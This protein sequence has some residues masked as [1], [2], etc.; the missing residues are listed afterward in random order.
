MSR[1][2]LRPALFGPSAEPFSNQEQTRGITGELGRILEE[3]VM[4]EWR[5]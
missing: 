4:G 1:N 2:V 3:V 5:Y